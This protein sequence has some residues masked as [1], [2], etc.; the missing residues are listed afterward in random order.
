MQTTYERRNRCVICPLT[1]EAALPGQHLTATKA[2]TGAPSLPQ[3]RDRRMMD[4]VRPPECTS[5]PEA[6]LEPPSA[7]GRRASGL[8]A[9]RRPTNPRSL[10]TIIRTLHNALAFVL[11]QRA[12]EGDAPDQCRVARRGLANQG[13]GQVPLN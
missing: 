7:G 12:Q 8:P 4:L 5:R 2:K 3:P 1:Q 11:C 10:P 13:K 6:T 9:E